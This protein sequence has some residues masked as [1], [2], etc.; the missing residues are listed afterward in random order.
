MNPSSES[1]RSAIQDHVRRVKAISDKFTAGKNLNKAELDFLG[2]GPPEEQGKAGRP[3]I[4]TQGFP[5]Y[6]SMA[7]CAAATGIPLIVLKQL[8]EEGSPAFRF[9]RIDFKALIP[10]L[11]AAR[12]KRK[13]GDA[14]KADEI[15]ETNQSAVLNYWRAQREKSKF[16]REQGQLASKSQV[17]RDLIA[18]MAELYGSLDRVFCNQLPPSLIGLHE[19]DIRKRCKVEIERMKD[20]MRA[21]FRKY[22]SEP[23]KRSRSDTGESASSE[24]SEST[25]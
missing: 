14:A 22:E 24:S 16:E 7:S 15:S 17:Q 1:I 10:D 18:A 25:A 6:T 23:V 21:C 13:S 2:L 11:I 20:A 3:P 19:L 5:V 4:G 12:S 8:K 9:S